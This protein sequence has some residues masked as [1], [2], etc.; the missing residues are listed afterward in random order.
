[1]PTLRG[2]Y[3]VQEIGVFGSVARGE[4]TEIS[5]IDILVEFSEP[6]GFFHFLELESFL[7]SLFGKRVDLVT[8]KALKSA[9]RESVLM[10]V[11]YA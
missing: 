3:H 1:M 2:T 7:G 11:Q 10:E 4:D 6:V 8:R 5:D 9:I